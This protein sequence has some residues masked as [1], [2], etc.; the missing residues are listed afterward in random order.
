MS[1]RFLTT[2]S[3]DVSDGSID[4]YGASIGADDLNPYMPVKTNASRRLESTLLAISDTNGLQAA[5][6][7][8]IQNPLQS[9]LNGGQYKILNTNTIDIKTGTNTATLEYNGG[10]DIIVDVGLLNAD[11]SYGGTPP[12]TANEVVLF[13]D[14]TGKVVKN[15]GLLETNIFK[16]DG[17]AP[18]N[19]T[20]R[21]V[22]G[23]A[24]APGITFADDIKTGIYKTALTS[25]LNVAI[26]GKQLA[27]FSTSGIDCK[28]RIVAD[29]N[30]G[31]LPVYGFAADNTSGLNGGIGTVSIMNSGFN[32][33]QF[34]AS[35]F[36]SNGQAIVYNFYPG[37][38]LDKPQYSGN[39]TD[40]GLYMY[41]LAAN[42]VSITNDGL[43]KMNFTS[44]ANISLQ[45][46]AVDTINEKT[47]DN[48][49]NIDSLVLKRTGTTSDVDVSI[50]DDATIYIGR[51][52]ATAVGL[53]R[54]G[55]NTRAYGTLT[56]S[57][58]LFADTITEY[59][60]AAGVQIEDVL[61]LD[62]TIDRKTA[63]TMAI[64]GT[65]QTALNLG[66][67]GT[68]TSINGTLAT[69]TINEITPANGV[70]ID[71]VLVKDKCIAIST[72]TTP[73]IATYGGTVPIGLTFNSINNGFNPMTFRT[74]FGGNTTEMV[75]G[76]Y[77]PG[78]SAGL[79]FQKSVSSVF[80][81]GTL[82]I[83]YEGNLTCLRPSGTLKAPIVLTNAVN[84]STAT[85]LNI[86]TSTS[87][88][89]SIGASGID[90]TINGNL[91]NAL[92][93]FDIYGGSKA[94]PMSN[95]TVTSVTPATSIQVNFGTDIKTNHAVNFTITTAGRATYTGTLTR[96]FHLA[97]TCSF[98]DDKNASL[99]FYL[100]KN[101]AIN[102]TAIVQT[103]VSNNGSTIA[104]HACISLATNDYVE[105][106]CDSSVASTTI[107]ARYANM[108]GSALLN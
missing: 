54:A 15:S 43:E 11:V 101:G 13:A 33:Y 39:R 93:H 61:M 107:T 12:T 4:I 70:V 38:N 94:T 47:P 51:T 65:T 30:S 85:T 35:E 59:N 64:G 41:P 87:T 55:A 102:E 20:F 58:G 72:D 90:T 57:Q 23:T 7:A 8:T 95:T 74:T 26:D 67:S 56:A 82:Q 10:A 98:D 105:L 1:N 45:P 21:A 77:P 81:Y 100:Y 97:Y 31:V 99:K 17:D 5:L 69:N 89:V 106:W 19:G 60:T 68:T 86:G 27:N 84:G 9:N 42:G 50:F 3:G 18:I 29:S 37:C 48:G 14:T 49:V 28:N 91:V 78:A 76:C 16:T 62:A 22:A 34:S 92:P 32:N 71:G 80:Q 108:F 2:S 103:D 36:R 25:D 83:D 104:F 46:I 52:N 6:N 63:G 75:L 24:A 96:K 88:A 79:V 44:T 40:S 53:S 73:A 66:R